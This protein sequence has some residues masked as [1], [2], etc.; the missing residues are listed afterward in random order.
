MTDQQNLNIHLISLINDTV[1]AMLAT[2]YKREDVIIGGI[3]GTGC[4]SA[5]ME[6]CGHIPKLKGD[7]AADRLMAINCE[8]GAFDNDLKVLPITPYDATI[9]RES[10]RPGQQ[11]FEKL[12]AGLYLGEILRLIIIEAH[13]KGSILN[14]QSLNQIQQPYCIDTSL[15][16]DLEN[17][18]SANLETT[19][20]QLHDKY[21]IKFSDEEMQF[22]LRV[23][24]AI[25]VRGS[26]LCACGVS[27]ICNVKGISSGAVAADGSVAEKHPMFKYRWSHALS[28]IL[29]WSADRKEDP[30]IMVPAVDGSGIGAAV[31]AAMTAERRAKG[32]TAGLRDA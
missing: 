5:Y 4:N 22:C 7:L 12:S 6:K 15:L 24:I 19:Q 18:K 3:F 1:G 8:Y 27:A 2:A 23:A 30:V 21:G 25:A 28:E 31:I 17:D 16:S 29:D 32:D 9:D 10:P 26:R 13:A 14:G 11:R 20:K